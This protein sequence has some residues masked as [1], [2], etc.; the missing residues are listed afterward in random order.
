MT[1]GPG[2]RHFAP[3]TLLLLVLGGACRP[4]AESEA[5][6]DDAE[7]KRDDA[8]AAHD[9]R[10]DV[11]ARLGS[12][13]AEYAEALR[14]GSAAEVKT[15]W[16]EDAHVFLPGL[17]L[18]GAGVANFVDSFYAGGGEVIAVEFR[19]RDLFVHETAAYEIG[20]LEETARFGGADPETVKENY[21]VRWER[22]EDGSWRIDRFVAGPVEGPGGGL[23]R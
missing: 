23:R 14:R 18:D 4:A 17:E 9:A 15:F 5:K 2:A 19:R 8:S 20:R 21:F 16:S 12:R 1:E 7:A 6:R 13:M 11:R 22:Q 10:A 3:L